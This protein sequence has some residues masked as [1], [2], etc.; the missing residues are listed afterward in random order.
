[1]TGRLA[2]R[3]TPRRRSA[4]RRGRVLQRHQLTPEL[5]LDVSRADARRAR[6]REPS[7][8]PAGT[9]TVE[10]MD[11]PAAVTAWSHHLEPASLLG[12]AGELYGR[13]PGGLRGQRRRRVARRRATSCRRRWRPR[14]GVVD[15]LAAL[16]AGQAAS[17]EHVAVTAMHE[18]S[19]VAELIS[20]CERRGRAG[21]SARSRSPCLEHP[22]AGA[23]AGVP[24]ADR[25]R[26]DGGGRLEAEAFDVRAPVWLRIR[27]RPRARRPDQ[28]VR[29]GVPGLRR[30]LDVAT[31]GRARTARD[32]NGPRLT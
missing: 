28:R 27:G 5:A 19:L 21:R 8:R 23:A 4:A 6:R 20:E 15:A 7:A 32:A 26:L 14:A 31:N 29:R 10:P 1:M 25:G 12:L 17:T 30:C 2:R 16:I 22:G 13:A 9:F 18:V 11:G 3:G 24:D